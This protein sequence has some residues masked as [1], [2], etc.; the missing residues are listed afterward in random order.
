[1]STKID[2][3]SKLIHESSLL[4]RV[5]S[6]MVAE[7]VSELGSF[8]ITN[9]NSILDKIQNIY[10]YGQNIYLILKDRIE[11]IDWNGNLAQT[12]VAVKSHTCMAISGHYMYIYNS[13]YFSVL[14][15]SD[16]GQYL[17]DL[18]GSGMGYS[19]RFF[20]YRNRLYV[21]RP[22]SKAVI[23]FDT[24]NNMELFSFDTQ[25]TP[26]RKMQLQGMAFIGDIV[27]I[28][29]FIGIEEWGFK[30][31]VRI[32]MFDIN[33]TFIKIECDA[34][35]KHVGSHYTY[36]MASF[37]G[38]L[39]LTYENTT[40]LFVFSPQLEFIKSIDIGFV[41]VDIHSD[42]RHLYVLTQDNKILTF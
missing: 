2:V 20:S 9:I 18:I 13:S 42:E 32:Q 37:E 25:Y 16:E 33:G 29:D 15:L 8:H 38:K 36:C 30:P 26:F 23:V 19:S 6:K 7:Y 4:P 5:I 41:V 11:K 27:Y 1:M 39:I 17:N 34:I 31:E 28:L 35:R 22:H 12:Y 21:Q 40:E 24:C 14:I 10:V 3:T